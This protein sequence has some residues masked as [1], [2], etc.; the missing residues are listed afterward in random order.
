[1]TIIGHGFGGKRNTIIG[2]GYGDFAIGPPPT[3]LL[4]V[5][6]NI[7]PVCM[8]IENIMPV[9]EERQRIMSVAKEV[10]NNMAVK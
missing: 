8:T 10:I 6:Q 3:Q 5:V 7:M 4:K 9:R 2:H 1:M